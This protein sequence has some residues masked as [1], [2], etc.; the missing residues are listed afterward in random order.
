M[1][2]ALLMAVCQALGMSAQAL[3]S[4]SIAATTAG[5]S[6]NAAAKSVR[7]EQDSAYIA[8]QTAEIERLLYASEMQRMEEAQKQAAYQR[9]FGSA[10]PTPRFSVKQLVLPAAMIAV[11]T[12]AVWESN[13]KQMNQHIYNNIGDSGDVGNYL[14]YAPL[15]LKVGLG[16]S[17]VPSKYSRMDN[18][19][20]SVTSMAV[21]YSL[22]CAMKYTIR[23]RRPYDEN[24]RN[25]FPAIP[26]ARAVRSAEMIR[27]EYGNWW[28]L[29][30]YTLAAAVAYCQMSNGKNWATD[31]LGG[32]GVGI[33]SARIG[34][35]LVPFER[36]LFGL[37][38]YDKKTSQPQVS[39]VAVPYYDATTRSAGASVA[40][41]F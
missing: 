4:D 32:I 13:L 39:V 38:K 6:I 5:D 20:A 23:E 18:L 21:M 28:G 40:L 3:P 22:S 25:S 19:L 37:D 9:L 33:L 35:W 27:I 41:A 14:Q 29:G 17:R 1:I 36:R 31:V 2:L 7:I 15:A 10:A 8:Q 24:E 16:F 12:V 34:Y 26:V 30:G 11:G